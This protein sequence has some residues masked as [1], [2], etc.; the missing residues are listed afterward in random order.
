MTE[1]G[2]TRDAALGGR[3][4]VL[5]E[6]N[7]YRFSLDAVLLAFFIRIKP[8]S[9]LCDL[10]TG[11]GIIP[12]ILAHQTDDIRLF[13]VEIQ[14]NLA[15]LARENVRIN[16]FESRIS[17]LNQD[18]KNLPGPSLPSKM[19]L[20]CSNP[21]YRSLGSGRVNPDSSKALA[22]HEI[23]A[24]LKDAAAAASRLLDP[25]GLFFTVYPATRIADLFSYLRA[26]R[27]EP[28]RMRLVHSTEDGPARLILVESVK[29]GGRECQVEP[30]LIL[31]DS[32][33]KYTAEAGAMLEA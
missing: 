18:L 27:L 7:G 8:G 9:S 1:A 15:R 3:L 26:S 24:G 21:P 20:V 31:Y 14:E 12:L 10:G 30:P 29:E 32:A 19:D 23:L 28:K 13:G 5:Q 25:S 16:G 33:G 11:C 2:I 6:K 4:R 22:R 17:I